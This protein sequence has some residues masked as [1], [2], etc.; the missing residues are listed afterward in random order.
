MM[1]DNSKEIHM[2]VGL[3]YIFD[4]PVVIEV[5]DEDLVID[6]ELAAKIEA[7]YARIDELAASYYAA[8]DAACQELE[9]LYLEAGD[10]EEIDAELAARIA[11][12]Y[13]TLDEVPAAMDTALQAAYAELNALIEQ[14][15]QQVFVDEPAI[16]EVPDDFVIDPELAAKIEE[17][18]GRIAELEAPYHASMAAAYD[19]VNGLFLGGSV[20]LSDGVVVLSD[21]VAER[22][23]A[24]HA[25][26]VG[27]QAAM[28][29]DPA[30]QAAYAA[31]NALKTQLPVVT[32]YVLEDYD[33]V[34]IEVPDESLVIDPE[35]I[36]AVEPE[37]PTLVVCPGV[38]DDQGVL[39]VEPEEP[40]F[41]A[42]PGV[43][44]GIEP[45]EP[46]F[47]AGP[48]ALVLGVEPEEPTLV[49]C[50]EDPW[51]LLD[52]GVNPIDTDFAPIADYASELLEVTNATSSPTPTVK[53]KSV[54]GGQIIHSES[55]VAVKTFSLEELLSGEVRF[56]AA[57]DKARFSLDLGQHADYIS[58]RAGQRDTIKG[59]KGDDWLDGNGGSDRVS[60]GRGDDRIFLDDGAVLSLDGGRG[61]D[62]AVFAAGSF[63]LGGLRKLAGIELFELQDGTDVNLTL[64][65]KSLFANKAEA[66]VQGDA[67]D[68]LTLLGDHVK[69]GSADG[70]DTWQLSWRGKTTTL[71]VDSDI[72]VV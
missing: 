57:G 27:I 2:E 37:E 72:H 71:L 51:P 60:G 32:V 4:D 42:G 35:L 20:V 48:G 47:V 65:V 18:Y 21:G 14:G 29:A 49:V 6:P 8:Y 46:A 30:L 11:A 52:P 19:G 43:L 24:V 45:R 16:I 3:E 22:I 17:A 13:A 12:V 66:R 28:D 56:D 39:G 34:V 26:L 33:N 64:S 41:V 10:A 62:T 44:V 58:G 25:T 15:G 40:T 63:D 55:G 59:G 1:S 53:V 9:A 38:D 31:L 5:P 50:F 36:L 23:N 68:S 70:F 7:A 67:G 54:H 61:S 69:I